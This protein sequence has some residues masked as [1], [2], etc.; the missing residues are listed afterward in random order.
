[1]TQAESARRLA[2]G[3][4]LNREGTEA[5]LVFPEGVWHFRD[6]GHARW[7]EANAAERLYREVLEFRITGRRLVLRFRDGST[8]VASKTWLGPRLRSR[9]T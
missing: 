1:M 6:D 3:F 4:R 2:T 5:Q 7:S 9:A 8:L